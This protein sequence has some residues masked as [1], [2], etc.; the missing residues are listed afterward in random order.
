MVLNIS[1]ILVSWYHKQLFLMLIGVKHQNII[2]DACKKQGIQGMRWKC[3]KCHDFDLCTA[4]YMA[5]KHDLGHAFLRIENA[6]SRGL[7]IV[8]MR[9]F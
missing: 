9:L 8:L 1:C 4:C 2:C 7:V 3:T 6:L 5:D